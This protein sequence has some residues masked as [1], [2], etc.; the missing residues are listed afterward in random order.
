MLLSFQLDI[1]ASRGDIS[2][3]AW[4]AIKL[5]SSKQYGRHPLRVG[6]SVIVVVRATGP[7]VYAKSGVWKGFPP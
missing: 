6:E 1:Q 3:P 7:A 4:Q 2:A 5:T